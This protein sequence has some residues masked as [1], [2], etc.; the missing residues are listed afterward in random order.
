MESGF[1]SSII[2][3]YAECDNQEMIMN[4]A[5]KTPMF[6][7]WIHCGKSCAELLQSALEA[8]FRLY[9]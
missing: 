2:S 6:D 8:D 4:K 9:T 7:L 3:I 5:M 1:H